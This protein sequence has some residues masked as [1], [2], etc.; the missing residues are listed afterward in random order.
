MRTQEEWEARY[1]DGTT[2]WHT[3]DPEP[4][5]NEVI[6]LAGIAPC[7]AL[8]IGCGEG[9]NARWLARRGF[10][11]TGIDISPTAIER[12]RAHARGEGVGCDFQT[13][14][15]LTEPL[16]EAD[17]GFVFDRGCFHSFDAP[18]ERTTYAQ[19]VAELLG[20]GG[21]WLSLIG[22]ADDPPREVGPPRRSALE[23][24]TAVEPFFEILTL[25]TDQFRALP[26]RQPRIWSCLMR[27]R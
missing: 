5:L 4:A 21:L 18:E 19:R 24:I 26:E 7:R 13:L 16:A 10:S 22:S 11:V 6:E 25:K 8:E 2:P 23:I 12:A 15:F 3:M 17:Y 27:K 20:E 14:N 1:L 9:S